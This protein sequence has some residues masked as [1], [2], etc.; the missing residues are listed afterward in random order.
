MF[1]LQALRQL[2]NPTPAA[3]T[4]DTARLEE[5]FSRGSVAVVSAAC[6]DAMSTPK[7]AELAGNLA[8]ALERENLQRPVAFG[9]LTG[10]REQLRDAGSTLDGAGLDFRNQLGALFQT[11]GLAAFPLLLIDGRIAFY[12]GVPSIDAIAEKLRSTLAD[13]G[14]DA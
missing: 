11:Q 6:C 9:T 7:D 12:G 5:L 4:G 13:K 14:L 1:G 10:T 3:A 2:F 8:S